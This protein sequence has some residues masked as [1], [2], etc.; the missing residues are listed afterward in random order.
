VNPVRRAAF[1]LNLLSL[2]TPDAS[3]EHMRPIMFQ[4]LNSVRTNDAAI[5]QK[6]AN[7]VAAQKQWFNNQQQ[8]MRD[9]QAAN[10]AQHKKYYAD[11]R[12]RARSNDNFDESLRGVRTVEDTQTGVKTSVDLGN[13]DKVVDALNDGDPGRYRQIPLRDE[14]HP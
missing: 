9:Q 14:A 2:R 5:R 6:S 12:E 8:T 3:F 13:V 7:H 10:D 1:M 4:M 11:Q